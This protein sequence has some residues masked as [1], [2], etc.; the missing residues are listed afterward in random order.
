M[1]SPEERAPDTLDETLRG[2]QHRSA[3]PL[4]Y[5]TP[6]LYASIAKHVGD[7]MSGTVGNYL[8]A[9]HIRMNMQKGG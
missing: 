2:F 3:T 7:I 4:G 1:P 5:I 6:T 8:T 9:G